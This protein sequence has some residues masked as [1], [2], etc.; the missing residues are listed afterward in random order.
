MG[1]KPRNLHDVTFGYYQD[2]CLHLCPIF[3]RL[4][5][6]HPLT[7][8]LV[9]SAVQQ[10]TYAERTDDKRCHLNKGPRGIR[11]PDTQFPRGIS[12]VKKIKNIFQSLVRVNR[13]RDRGQKIFVFIRFVFTSRIKL[14]RRSINIVATTQ[15]SHSA[16]WC[17]SSVRL[18]YETISGVLDL[19]DRGVCH[20]PG[21]R[22]YYI[23]IQ[24]SFINEFLKNIFYSVRRNPYIGGIQGMG[25]DAMV[26]A[27]VVHR[28]PPAPPPPPLPPPH[29]HQVLEK[30]AISWTQVKINLNDG[31]TNAKTT[32]DGNCDGKYWMENVK[33]S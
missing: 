3:R 12:L 25:I 32:L 33:I 14:N 11:A 19:G 23:V 26:D 8:T 2:L 29:F 5:W 16:S 20:V 13:L 15:A 31:I 27:V 28:P 10:L 18:Q 30:N 17:I 9:L 22:K 4:S 6:S 21:I 1:Q 24:I 7:A